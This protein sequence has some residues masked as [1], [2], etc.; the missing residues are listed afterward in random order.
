MLAE[1]FVTPKGGLHVYGSLRICFGPL[2]AEI[3]LTGFIMT[4]SFPTKAEVA[5]S[6]FPLEV[7]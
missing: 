5:F 7:G 3:R 6:K 2:C 4:M 1:P